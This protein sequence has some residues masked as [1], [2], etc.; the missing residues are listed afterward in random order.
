M[1]HARARR[2]LIVFA[3]EPR[4]GRAKRRLAAEIGPVAAIA[5][6][7][8]QLF[9]TLRVLG[10]RRGWTRHLFVDPP[11]ARRSTLWPR[12]WEPRAQCPGDLGRRMRHALL[13]PPTGPVVLVGSDIPGVTPR[14]IE[15]AF[16]ALGRADLVLGPATDGGYWLIGVRRLRQ[17]PDFGRVRWSSEHAL[18]DTIAG[19]GKGCRVALIDRLSDVDQAAD[20]KRATTPGRRVRARAGAA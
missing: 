3:K 7:R 12:G 18:A 20:L 19:F 16:K 6:Y 14:H 9:R 10:R 4:L 15:A 11:T 17:P 13:S 5:W 2:H 8:N 1:A